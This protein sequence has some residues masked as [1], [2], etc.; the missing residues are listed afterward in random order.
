M[1]S[2]PASN[3]YAS[4]NLTHHATSRERENMLKR[5]PGRRS[6]KPECV[7][8]GHAWTEEP[9]REGGTICIVCNVVRLA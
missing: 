8:I 6:T 9:G 4:I 7:V 1:T 2:D 3:D 5:R